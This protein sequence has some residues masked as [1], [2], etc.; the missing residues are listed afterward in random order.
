MDA[1][2]KN[3]SLEIVIEQVNFG[4]SGERG[5]RTRV[6]ECLRQFAGCVLS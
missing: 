6:A 2:V 5:R 1:A 3:D 4:V